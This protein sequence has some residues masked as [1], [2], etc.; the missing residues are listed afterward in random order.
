MGHHYNGSSFLS[1]R[2]NKYRPYISF[3]K[4]SGNSNGFFLYRMN[5]LEPACKKTY[6]AIF[7]G[8]CKTIL[9]ITFNRAAYFS[10]LGSYLMVSSGMKIYFNKIIF[11]RS[12]FQSIGQA[13]FL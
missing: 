4:M 13:P 3:R 12:A 9:Q 11:L 5:K 2:I 10:K 6:S 1:N 8:S 7:I